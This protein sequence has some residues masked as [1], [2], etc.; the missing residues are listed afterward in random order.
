M[1]D[2]PESA[3]IWMQ[4]PRSVYVHIPFCT[5]RCGYCNFALVT[6]RDDLVDRFLDALEVE[7]KRQTADFET[8]LPVQTLF[9]GGGTPTYLSLDQIDRLMEMLLKHFRLQT[10]LA[11]FEFS[12]E[13]NPNDLQGELVQHF[14]SHAA[15]RFS[16]GA[17]SFQESKLTILERSHRAQHIRSAAEL[18]KAAGAELSLDL[19]F[20]APGE[21]LSQW[22]QDLQAAIDCQPDHVSTYQL[23]FEK[24]TQFWNRLQKGKLHET[25]EDLSLEMYQTAIEMLTAAGLR[26]YEVSNFGRPEKHSRHNCVYWSG[27]P[28]FAFGPA[29]ARYVNGQRI[30]NHGSTTTY[31]RRLLNDEDPAHDIEALDPELR[32]RECFVFGMRML[33]GVNQTDFQR[34]TGYNILELCGEQIQQDIRQGFIESHE[35]KS[36]EMTYRLSPQGLYLSDGLWP[37]YL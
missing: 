16:L 24:G 1:N 34:K 29:A 37:K 9:L 32:A 13:A 36:G 27:R 35:Y 31:I 4:T 5:Q 28:Y 21:T 8:P 2:R 19:I 22:Q 7:L 30:V 14:V 20:A 15:N 26:H 33:Q 12:V 10:D 25:D 17:Q 18:I 6:G 3:A 11:D 23:T